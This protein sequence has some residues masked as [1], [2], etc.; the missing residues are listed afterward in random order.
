MDQILNTSS[1]KPNKSISRLAKLLMFIFILL[2]IISV[3]INLYYYFDTQKR[4]TLVVKPEL[5]LQSDDE[6]E[7]PQKVQKLMR[8]PQDENPQIFTI[9]GNTPRNQPL[10]KDAKNGDILL[11]Y[12]KNQKAILYDPKKNQILK[13]GPLLFSSPSAQLK[14]DEIKINP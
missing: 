5:V 3:S 11:L 4:R 14:S 9:S 7:A 6:Q 12:I 2:F 10:I 1:S 8:L 13:V